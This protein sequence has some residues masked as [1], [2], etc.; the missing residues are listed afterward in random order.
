MIYKTAIDWAREKKHPEIV[1]LLS[2][3]P[4]KKKITSDTSTRTSKQDIESLLQKNKQLEDENQ[5]MKR[6]LLAMKEK[7]TTSLYFYELNDYETEEVIGQGATSSVKIVS[8]TAKEKYAQ[9][10]LKEFTFETMKRF[11]SECEILFK[12]RHP[13]IVRVYG[14]N[15]G[16]DTHPPSMILSLE[17][18]SLEQA[19]IDKILDEHQ[20]NRITIELVLGMRYIHKKNFMHR[21]LKPKNILLSKNNHVRITDFGLAKEE[22]LET[23]QILY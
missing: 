12:L 17:P 23:S 21:D 13:C 18:T 3:G 15:N 11:L 20:K 14:F 4:I 7:T 10:E 2:K 6:Y 19:I 9:K 1:E 5:R 16:D 22:D 8:K